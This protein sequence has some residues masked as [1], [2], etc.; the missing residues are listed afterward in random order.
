MV[1]TSRPAAARPSAGDVVPLGPQDEA[2]LLWNDQ[3]AFVFPIDPD[4]RLDFI[5]WDRTFGVRVSEELAGTSTTFSLSVEL[6]DGGCGTRT[7]PMAGLSWVAVHPGYRRRGV[8]T[9]MIRDHLHRL[10]DEGREPVSGLHA[11]ES[12]IYGRFGY[13]LATV[14][15]QLSLG[16]DVALRPLTGA[17]AAAA[18]GLRVRFETA[19][20]ERHGDLVHELY[21][22]ACRRRPGMVGRTRA[23]TLADLRDTPLELQRNEPLRLLVAERDGVP[24]GYALLRRSMRW[25]DFAPDGTVEVRELAAVDRATEHRLWRAVTQFDLTGRAKAGRI[26]TDDPLLSWLVDARAAKPVRTDELWLRV[27]DVDRALTAR[28]YA[29]PVDVVLQVVD[30]MCPW[31]DGRWRLHADG[32]GAAECVRTDDEPHLALDVRELGAM[33]AGGTTA[34]TLAAAGLVTESAPGAARTLS[35]A[36]RSDVEPAT[37]YGF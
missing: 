29:E 34:S 14:G 1:D 22:Q 12:A 18:E 11:S 30:P 6:P 32:A 7:V 3:A 36:M 31:N 24:T 20:P 26:A 9:T 33:L 8:L 27:V 4:Y 16:R 17:Q 37:T 19:D 25:E 5:E 13:G 2:A 23:L 28:G 10:H 35:R 21:H 15:Y